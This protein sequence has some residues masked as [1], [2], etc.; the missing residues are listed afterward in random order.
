LRLLDDGSL[1]RV[2]E[3]LLRNGGGN[4][5]ACDHSR[6]LALRRVGCGELAAV[7]IEALPDRGGLGPRGELDLGYPGEVVVLRVGQ[8]SAASAA[9]EI[10]I[11]TPRTRAATS[12][13]YAM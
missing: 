5:L 6:E 1:R 10:V 7:A 12:F 9:G 3:D 2:V 11:R 4:S 8:C 13:A